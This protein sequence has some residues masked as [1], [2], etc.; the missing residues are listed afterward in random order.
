MTEHE[1]DILIAEPEEE[2]VET[3][4]SAQDDSLFEYQ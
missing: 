4:E 3:V 1:S 2:T